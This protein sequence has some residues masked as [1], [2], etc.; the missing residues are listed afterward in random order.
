MGAGTR[1]AVYTVQGQV[2]RLLPP[3]CNPSHRPLKLKTNHTLT[4]ACLPPGRPSDTPRRYVSELTASLAPYL[5]RD[6]DRGR[7]LTLTLVDVGGQSVPLPHGSPSTRGKRRQGH[8][9]EMHATLRFVLQC[10]SPELFHELRQGLGMLRK[11][12]GGGGGP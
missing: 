4:P 8:D 1:S 3:H 12:G 5:L 6:A 2:S 9:E 11:H 10:L 7:P